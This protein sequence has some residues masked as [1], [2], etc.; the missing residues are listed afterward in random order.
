MKRWACLWIDESRT[1]RIAG[2]FF[3]QKAAQRWG[4]ASK[5]QY[6]RIEVQM[7]SPGTPDALES[8]TDCYVALCQVPTQHTTKELLTGAR[9]AMESLQAAGMNPITGELEP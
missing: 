3:S 9:K 6:N 4:E 5:P 1:S 8:L 2:P 7:D